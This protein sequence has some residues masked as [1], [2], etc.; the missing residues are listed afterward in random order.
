MKQKFFMLALALL[1]LTT[2]CDEKNEVITPQPQQT[3]IQFNAK[4]TRATEYQFE[5]G[6][7]ISVFAAYKNSTDVGE[8]A[9]NVKYSFANN[10]FTTSKELVYPESG[11]DLSFYAIYPY[12]NYSTPEF[13]FEVSNDQRSHSEYTTSDLM[14][15]SAVGNYEEVVDLT[16]KHRLSK[17]VINLISDKMPAGEQTLVLKDVRSCALADLSSNTYYA[18][19]SKTTD[20]IASSNGTNSFKVVLP[21][22]S[23]AKN[24][25]FAEIIIGNKVFEWVL[26]KDLI[27]NSGVEYTYNLEINDKSSIA[28]TSQID[29]WGTPEAIESVIP[30]EYINIIRDYIPIHE[31]TTP[32]NIEGTYFISPLVLLTDNV[33]YT[34]GYKFADQ[35]VMFYNQTYN[36][37]ISMQSTQLLGDLSVGSG[38]FISGSGEDFTV[39]FNGY[40]EHEDGSYLTTASVISGSIRDGYIYD[41]YHAFI[42]LDDYDVNGTYMDSGQYRIL[43]DQDAYSQ[44][45][46]WP[47]DTRSIKPGNGVSIYIK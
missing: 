2:S 37:T 44:P 31:G 5:A 20:I 14:T 46:E 35:Y 6:D 12:A 21:P 8:Y 39:Y 13:Q 17:V 24:T 9:K 1:A 27:L 28:F 40:S 42:V 7:E 34:P 16:F 23:F 30:Q 32:P 22:Q 15:A 41:Y 43:Y 36:N 19:N 45:T 38:L 29:P 18:S 26:T 33:G 3:N 11:D 10:L 25:L 4:I 47:L